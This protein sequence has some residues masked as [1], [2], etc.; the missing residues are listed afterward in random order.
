M[1]SK[2]ELT[3]RI[4]ACGIAVHRVLGPGFVESTYEAAF[5]VELAERRIAFERQLVVPVTYKDRKIGE[6]RPD[7]VVENRVVVE[8][9]SVEQL[10]GLHRAQLRAYMRVLNLPVGLLLNFNSE[11]LR[12]GIQRLDL[13]Q[14]L[15]SS[16]ETDVA[17]ERPSLTKQICGSPRPARPHPGGRSRASRG[18]GARG[19]RCP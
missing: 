14:I 18:G 15:T 4:I 9:K 12:S 10:I 16:P 7:L 3:E 19:R 8:I 11:V 17:G 13:P 5:C 2:D 6:Y 1:Y